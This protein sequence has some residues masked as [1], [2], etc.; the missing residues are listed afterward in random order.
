MLNNDKIDMV[1]TRQELQFI[2]RSYMCLASDLNLLSWPLP[3]TVRNLGCLWLWHENPE[4][5][6]GHLN[7]YIQLILISFTIVCTCISI[8]VPGS[9]NLLS[10]NLY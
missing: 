10:V 4:F 9:N 3:Q 6:S 1:N 2:F 7:I 5:M 8:E